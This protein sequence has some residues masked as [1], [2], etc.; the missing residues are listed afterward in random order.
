M[1]TIPAGA[2][3]VGSGVGELGT[4][5]R[6]PPFTTA[7]LKTAPVA[8]AGAA[9]VTDIAAG[10]LTWTRTSALSRVPA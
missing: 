8:K 7:R 9:T 5:V 3:P 1:L 6:V 2:P 4:S 10:L